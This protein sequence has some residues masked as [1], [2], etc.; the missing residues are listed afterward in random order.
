LGVSGK[1]WAPRLLG[2]HPSRSGCFGFGFGSGFAAA[3]TAAATV[4]AATEPAFTSSLS[5]IIDGMVNTSAHIQV[6][7]RTKIGT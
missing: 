5:V 6:A 7:I 4:A 1:G 2:L 3:A